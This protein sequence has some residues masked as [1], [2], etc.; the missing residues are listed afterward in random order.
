MEQ[1]ARPQWQQPIPA[2]VEDGSKIW[3]HEYQLK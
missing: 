2:L 1:E 3:Q